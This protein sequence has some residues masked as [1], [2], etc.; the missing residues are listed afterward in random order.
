MIL[1]PESLLSHLLD[2]ID[3]LSPVYTNLGDPSPVKTE[4]LLLENKFASAKL[5]ETVLLHKRPY[6]FRR[7]DTPSGASIISTETAYFKHQF[8][9]RE[10][11]NFNLG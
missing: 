2:G 9:R 6:D 5:D 8:D 7:R 10:K 1:S 3:E 11:L 4:D